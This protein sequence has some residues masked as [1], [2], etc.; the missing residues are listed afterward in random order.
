MGLY[1]GG[2]TLGGMGGRLAGAAIL[3]H[4]GWRLAIGLIGAVSLAGAV[5]FALALP[6]ERRTEHGARLPKILSGPPPPSLRSGPA[7][8]VR[9]RLPA[10]GQLRHHLQLHRLPPRRAAFLAR[11]RRRSASSSCFISSERS[12]LADRG[13]AC[14]P[15][16]PAQ[17]D[18]LRHRPDAARRARDAAGQCAADRPRRRARDRGFLRRPF[19]RV[20][21]GRPA[22]REGA[23]AGE[24]A[25]SVLLLSRLQHRGLARRVRLRA[26]RV[27]RGRASSSAR[28]SR[29]PSSSRCGC[30][31]CRRQRICFAGPDR[32]NG[33]TK[34]S[35]LAS[36]GTASIP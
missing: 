10:D 16:R 12:S 36:A 27:A 34:G 5:L 2:S 6:R 28:S 21:L 33:A 22:R 19:D 17:G 3:E 30:R 11:A 1:I 32:W 23:R 20:E 7:L 18:R 13:R 8:S 29:S 15:V 14:G 9:A 31:A 25:L 24:R 35:S 26:W 4:G